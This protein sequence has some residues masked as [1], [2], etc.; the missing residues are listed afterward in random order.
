[1]E[2]L[3]LDFVPGK[4]GDEKSNK[5]TTREAYRMSPL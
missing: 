1:M 3:S 4:I 5:S 2:L